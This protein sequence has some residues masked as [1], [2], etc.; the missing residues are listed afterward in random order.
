ML[1][2]AWRF[3]PSGKLERAGQLELAAQLELIARSIS[4]DFFGVGF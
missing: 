1:I 3:C 4:L 2:H